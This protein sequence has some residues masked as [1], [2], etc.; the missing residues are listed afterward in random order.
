MHGAAMNI[1][2]P[3]ETE[4]EL[5]GLPDVGDMWTFMALPPEEKKKVEDARAAAYR[6]KN[7]DDLVEE[8]HEN[9][10]GAEAIVRPTDMFQHDQLIA[11]GMVATVVDPELGATTQIGVPLTL[12][13]APGAIQGPQPPAGAHTREL[14]AEADL[15]ADTVDALATLA[16][17]SIS[18]GKS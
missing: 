10:L 3:K 17:V 13:D 8:F 15:D 7:R 11:N 1:L 16:E 9:N 6:S 12:E 5:L 4:D 2:K 18:D 14:L